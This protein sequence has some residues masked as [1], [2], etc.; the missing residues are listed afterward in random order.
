MIE[1]L[2]KNIVVVTNGLMHIENFWLKVLKP[3]LFGGYVKPTT[4][5]MVGRGAIESLKTI[6]LINVLWV[7][8]GS[9]HNLALQLQIRRKQ[10]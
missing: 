2:P 4:K 1:F 5:A 10:W 8:M 7:L 3:Y 9:I 6:D